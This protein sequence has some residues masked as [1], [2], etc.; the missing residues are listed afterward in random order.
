MKTK[1]CSLICA[2]CVLLTLSCV[3]SSCNIGGQSGIDSAKINEDGELIIIYQDGSKQ[4]LGVVVGA[5]GK[6]GSD[7]VDGKDGIDG[8]NGVDGKDGKDGKDGE[9]GI[10]GVDGKD[11][12]DGQDGIDGVDGSD[13]Q[14]GIDGEN[15]KDGEDGDIVNMTDV[16]TASAKGLRSAVSIV[17]N[18]T[19]TVQNSGFFPGMGGGSKT[20]EYASAG[21]GVI[22]KINKNAGDAFII[23]NY[24]VVYDASSDTEN[25]ISDDISVFLYGSEMEEKAI[26]ATYVGGSLYYDIAVL[27]IDGS[28]ILKNSDASYVNIANS[29]GVMVGDTAI[30]IGNPQGYGIS[31]SFGVVSVDSEYITMTA[32][33]G[34]TEVS[35]RV[36][37]VDTAV[38]SGNSG[39]GLYNKNG[40]LIGIVNAKIVDDGVENIGYA[41]PSNIA[42]SVANNI[43]DYCYGKDNE[44][45]QRALLGISVSVS[46]SRA[47]YNSQTGLISI[48]ETVEVYEVSDGSIASGILKAGDVLISATLNGNKKDIT[49]RYH[50]IDLMLDV[51][52]GDVVE[53]AVLRG[54][55]EASVS[56]EITEDCLTAY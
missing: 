48:V 51:R 40:E 39:G 25:G 34:K 42:I 4:N 43:I 35:F 13:G 45:V 21:S 19:K 2:I 32:A 31:A 50:I 11:G 47:V 46:S 38:N 56:V 10:N 5:D 30:A 24:H 23:T 16:P 26:P 55:E 20:E 15:G 49:R 52:V 53:F 9:D 41:I 27:R 8:T 14:D 44:N 28:E 18:F 17:C 22:Y 1:I 6:D 12:K 29:D 37:R 36:M 33:D 7:G 3:F 54:G